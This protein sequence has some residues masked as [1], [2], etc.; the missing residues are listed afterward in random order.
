MDVA[1]ELSSSARTSDHREA[2]RGGEAPTAGL[3]DP[4]CGQEYLAAAGSELPH[5]AGPDLLGLQTT[6]GVTHPQPSR[7]PR[8]GEANGILWA[9]GG[10]LCPGGVPRRGVERRA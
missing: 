2:E 5:G 6:S 4:N 8:Q 7:F 10:T 1:A 9:H 3:N